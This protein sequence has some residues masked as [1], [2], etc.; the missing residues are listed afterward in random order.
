MTLHRPVALAA[1]LAASL[2]LPSAVRAQDA[3]APAFVGSWTYATQPDPIG[4]AI[5]RGTAEM[6]FVT[7]PI[8]RR[9]LAATNDAY[10]TVEIRFAGGNV[11]T[12]LAGRSITSP[13]DGREIEWR[14]EDGELLR[15]T[16]SLRDGT[17]V[18]TFTAE[19]GSRENV[20]SVAADGRL[21]LQATIRSPRLPA[22][23]T[24]RM[25]YERAR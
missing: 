10:S 18:Q 15:V 8:A 3:A 16:T 17:L 19:D 22:P 25:L 2:L 11:T 6:N 4:P 23:I 1:A 14:R 9:R 7:R 13:A 21:T 24:Y 5:Q 12:V 20:Y